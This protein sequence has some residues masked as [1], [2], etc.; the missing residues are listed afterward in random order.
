MKIDI[1]THISPPK[2]NETLSKVAI[3]NPSVKDRSRTTQ[4]PLSDVNRRFEFMDKFE[5]I[6]QVLTLVEPPIEQV[7]DSKKAVD[8]AKIANDELAELV[9]KH[10]DRFVA[11]V[12]ALPMNNMDAAL[13]EVDRAIKDLKLRGVQLYTSV[14]DK[15]LD[16][17]E[18]LPLYERMSQH[19]LPIW[20]HPLKKL[21]EPD[22]PGEQGSKYGL[23][24]VIGWPHATS[25]AMI[26]LAGSGVLEKFPTLKF[27]THHA[28][29]TVPYLAKRIEF[30][31]FTYENLSKP[32]THYLR[33][34]YYDTAVQGNTPNL[35]CAHAFCG[36]DHM[37]FGTDSPM[38]G[39]SLLKD[40]IRSVHAMN[41]PE[42]DKNKIFM[43]NAEKL[44]KLSL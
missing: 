3:E 1:F 30:A 17:P 44:L 42:A 5:D 13:Q 40:T 24:A 8:L 39:V 12:A 19:D 32:I 2:Y 11:A 33:S 26:R 37:L 43:E 10:P 29:G 14:N 22:Y 36:A 21:S 6:V 28:G 15:P 35:M 25:M 38:V 41:I 27:I 31:P 4:T 18:F 23:A 7:T 9:S 20:I 16:S 34:F